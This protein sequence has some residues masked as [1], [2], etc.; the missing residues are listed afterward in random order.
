[1]NADWKR[2]KILEGVTRS[3]KTPIGTLHLTYNYDGGLV[4]LIGHIGK[5]G[6]MMAKHID[7]ICR[8]M[9]IILQSPLSR[10]KLIKKIK[11]NLHNIPMDDMSFEH[12]GEKYE[13]IE[14]Y[15]FKATTK[16][17]EEK[18]LREELEK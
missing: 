7:I 2:P 16:E 5:E 3:V 12:E 15:I 10:V 8:L 13:S 9:S 1:M 17:L 14:D 18:E 4:E 11:K 6:S